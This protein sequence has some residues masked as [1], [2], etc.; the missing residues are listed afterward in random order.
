[1]C[2]PVTRSDPVSNSNYL[3]SIPQHVTT[4]LIVGGP[5][6]V[7]GGWTLPR[8]VV[9]SPVWRSAVHMHCRGSWLRRVRVSIPE[10]RF[11]YS[12]GIVL[13]EQRAISC[14]LRVYHVFKYPDSLLVAS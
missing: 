7:W 1:M 5:L 12:Y 11:G 6:R 10:Y 2:L 9:F 3:S 14:Q 8:V 13:E 4:W